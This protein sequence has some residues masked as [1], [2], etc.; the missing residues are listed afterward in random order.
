M[1]WFTKTV[2]AEKDPLSG[3]INLPAMF[4]GT[5]ER[6][7]AIK[8]SYKHLHK[9][10]HN[11][12]KILKYTKGENTKGSNTRKEIDTVSSSFL[13]IYN[14]EAYTKF[15][16]KSILIGQQNP[17]T[18]C[19]SIQRKVANSESY[20]IILVDV[21]M[22]EYVSTYKKIMQILDKFYDESDYANVSKELNVIQEV[23]KKIEDV[24]DNLDKHCLKNYFTKTEI[25]DLV[26]KSLENNDIEESFKHT[27]KKIKDR[28]S[29]VK[30]K[31]PVTPVA[32][33]TRK[34]LT[35]RFYVF[36]QYCENNEDLCN[37]LVDDD[38]KEIKDKLI[39][40]QKIS[41]SDF[42]KFMEDKILSKSIK[43]SASL[44][45]SDKII[46]DFIY[47]YLA[48]NK[49]TIYYHLI[50]IASKGAKDK[51]YIYIYQKL[52]ELIEKYI[53]KNN[54]NP[55]NNVIEQ[56]LEEIL[57]DIYDDFKP[58]ILYSEVDD[59]YSKLTKDDK[60]IDSKAF[61]TFSTA[62]FNKDDLKTKIINKA[63]EYLELNNNKLIKT[64]QI[65]G[66][67]IDQLKKELDEIQRKINTTAATTAATAAAATAAATQ[68]QP[69]TPTVK[70]GWAKL[71]KL[72][73]K[74]GRKTMRKGRKGSK[75]TRRHK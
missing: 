2:K 70:R 42:V 68:Q 27:M 29:S 28:I 18:A 63:K 47:K 12:E 22:K 9:I 35:E 45:T 55:N 8:E 74:G 40:T 72:T 25:D 52:S 51:D 49:P 48:I 54:K 73:W 1:G 38:L 67:M 50:P 71:P 17:Q 24:S 6:Q 3:Y 14:S 21:H 75:K 33:N 39:N 57:G 7:S 10:Y 4:K 16:E 41:Y 62:T 65:I 44:T 13:M 20:M 23:I 59:I 66:Y 43:A 26:K 58:V 31:A 61:N 5:Y 30:T 37:T 34:N 56:F 46:N 69:T 32:T 60:L 11:L 19:E 36:K 64:P 53:D 15:F